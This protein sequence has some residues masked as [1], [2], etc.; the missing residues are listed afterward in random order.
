MEN[1]YSIHGRVLTQEPAA[2]SPEPEGSDLVEEYSFNTGILFLNEGPPT[3]IN[4]ADPD[5]RT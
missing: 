2:P 4:K 5:C 1:L 3:P